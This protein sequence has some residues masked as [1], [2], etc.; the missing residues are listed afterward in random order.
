MVITGLFMFAIVFM[1]LGG[2]FGGDS[3]ANDETKNM[4]Q[5]QH[6]A[7]TA[8]VVDSNG[9]GN[10]GDASPLVEFVDKS[11]GDSQQTDKDQL[12]QSDMSDEEVKEF[13]KEVEVK[14]TESVTT[15][16]KE[17]GQEVD[18]EDGQEVVEEEVNKVDSTVD[19]E[20]EEE[21][22]QDN[23][24]I[25]N[26]VVAQEQDAAVLQVGREEISD[27]AGNMKAGGLRGR[28]DE[29]EKEMLEER[30]SQRLGKKVKLLIG[31][32]EIQAA[33]GNAGKMD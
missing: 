23:A 13:G 6:Q 18:E 29:I 20:D 14:S 28:V 3:S 27:A 22:G 17:D 32:D 33:L 30:L 9:G 2:N 7:T 11:L 15:E 8:T 31:D 1:S 25:G 5:A 4:G 16:L 10:E 19:T 26:D 12:E 21:E 24:T